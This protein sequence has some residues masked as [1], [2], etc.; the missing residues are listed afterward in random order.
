M[1]SKRL[2]VGIDLGTTHTV[3]AWASLDRDEAPR[4]FP[5]PQLVTSGEIDAR[6]LL[7]SC[8]YAPLAGEVTADP[9]GEAPWVTGELGRRRGGE[10]PGRLVTSAKSWLCHP[11]VDRTA[12]ILPWGAD[13]EAVPRISP[14]D[15]SARYLAHVRRTWDE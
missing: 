11:A 2:A 4:I 15:A 3:V 7:P 5:I 14:V 12:P 10:V 8:L 1:G 9:W 6:P 13:D